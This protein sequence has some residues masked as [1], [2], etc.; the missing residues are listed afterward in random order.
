MSKRL[1]AASCITYQTP[2]FVWIS[3]A[4]LTETFNRFFHHKRYGSNVP[5]PLEAQRR[6]TKRKNTGLAAVSGGGIPIDPSIVLGSTA[7]EAGWWRGHKHEHELRTV[8]PQQ[9][10]DS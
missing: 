4:L 5:G 3:D 2:K 10:T 9:G 1:A 6:A 7:N 8:G